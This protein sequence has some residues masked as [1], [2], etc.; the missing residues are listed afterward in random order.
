M[1]DLADEAKRKSFFFGGKVAAQNGF[2]L[3]PAMKFPNDVAELKWPILASGYSDQTV[4]E[5]PC[6][7]PP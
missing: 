5:L 6:R 4:G 1:R 7:F 3:N 2:E